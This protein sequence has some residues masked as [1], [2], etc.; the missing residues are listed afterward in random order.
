MNFNNE[1]N[2]IKEIVK[3]ELK[4][5]EENLISSISVKQPLQSCIVNFLTAPSKR[6]RPVI[7]ILCY[8]AFDKNLTPAHYDL[9]SAIELIHSAS[10]I[11]DD[12]IDESIYRRG[13]KTISSEFNNK[14]GVITGD[15]I[16]SIAM[17]KIINLNNIKI[18]EKFVQTI[19]NMC[20]GEINQNFDRFKIG[21]IENYIEKSKNKTAYLFESSLLS[22]FMLDNINFDYKKI[23]EFGLNFGIAFQIWDDLKNLTSYDEL[24]PNKNDIEEGIYNAAIIY[25]GSAEDYEAGIEKHFN[26]L[27]NYVNK[28]KENL[29]YLPENIYKQSLEKILELLINE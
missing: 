22:M 26:L 3:E 28:A 4:I 20:I 10:L 6:I 19:K 18:L 5:L 1:Y 2:K 24:K 27:N 21:T 16:L 7:C 17:E 14:L 11:H 12:I 9:L 8:K 23:S 15:Y 29:N 25:A 13:Q